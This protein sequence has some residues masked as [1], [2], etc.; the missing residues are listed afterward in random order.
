[1]SAPNKACQ[2]LAK[3][4]QFTCFTC[5]INANIGQNFKNKILKKKKRRIEK[6]FR[7]INKKCGESFGMLDQRQCKTAHERARERGRDGGRE[8]E[9]EGG[10]ERE[11]M[12]SIARVRTHIHTHTH[13]HTYA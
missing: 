2:Q 11:R 7:K 12:H 6:I 13:T 9:R 4:F 8:G 10:R 5:W 1:M 3:L